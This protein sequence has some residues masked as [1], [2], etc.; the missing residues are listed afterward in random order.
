MTLQITGLKVDGGEGARGGI[1]IG[2]TGTGKPI[3]RHH[4]NPAHNS[5]TVAE[6]NEAA[7]RHHKFAGIKH[8]IEKGQGSAKVRAEASKDLDLHNAQ[9]A[10]HERSAKRGGVDSPFKSG[11]AGK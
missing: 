7:E 5:F 11:H 10:L 3:Y 8:R 4:N 9:A 6:H 2:H 1:V